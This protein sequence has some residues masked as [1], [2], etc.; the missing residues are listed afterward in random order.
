MHI[1]YIS[2]KNI[3]KHR[4]S[5]PG[6]GNCTILEEIMIFIMNY[7]I[8]LKRFYPNVVDPGGHEVHNLWSPPIFTTYQ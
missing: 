6:A 5:D 8:F 7:S 1:H 3:V 2:T 4:T